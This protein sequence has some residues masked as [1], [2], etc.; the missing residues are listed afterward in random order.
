MNELKY[1]IK[2]ITIENLDS[3][4]QDCWENRDVQLKILELQKI[5]GFG[6]W[7]DSVC[8]GSLHCYKIDLPDW[9]DALFPEYGRKRLEDWPLG[10]PLLAAKA[11]GI[12]FNGPVWGHACFHVGRLV[13]THDSN[14]EYLGKGIGKALL[15]ASVK[16]AREHQYAG[17]IAHGGSKS[18][19]EY[20]VVM[21]C[22]P[23]TSYKRVGF[24][25]C[26]LEEDGAAMPWWTTAWDNPIIKEQ[27]S[28]SLGNS[29]RVKDI[30][31]RLMVLNLADK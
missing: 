30:C 13:N 4:N 25:V 29:D 5:L 1:I 19:L 28:Q 15:D 10:W 17:I 22:L 23:W 24:K 27:V 8:V 11:K 7:I 12:I 14:R 18:V 20:N 3:V 2:P 21:G 26:A 9:D 6:A 31:A 16:W